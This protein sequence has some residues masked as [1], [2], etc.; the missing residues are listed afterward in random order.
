[1]NYVIECTYNVSCQSRDG[2]I[3]ELSRIITRPGRFL[4]LNQD[5]TQKSDLM[6]CVESLI[7]APQNGMPEIDTK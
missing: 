2:D 7:T 4:F 3:G 1:M 6:D 5:I